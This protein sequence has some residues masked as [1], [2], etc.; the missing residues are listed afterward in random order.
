MTL[1]G[2]LTMDSGPLLWLHKLPSES[3]SDD[4]LR[5][6]FPSSQEM[7][8]SINGVK[9]NGGFILHLRIS[10]EVIGLPYTRWFAAVST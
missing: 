9:A 8:T 3:P 4:W 7:R 10:S 6:Y 5:S 2:I 1:K